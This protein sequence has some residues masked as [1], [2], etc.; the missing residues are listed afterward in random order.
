MNSAQ[1]FRKPHLRNTLIFGAIFALGVGVYVGKS[2]WPPMEVGPILAQENKDVAAPAAPP[3]QSVDLTEPQLKAIKVAPVAQRDFRIVKQAV[4]NVDFNQDMSTQVSSPYQGRILQI[5]AALG[6]RVERGQ[7][8][9]TIES[10][11]LLTAEA[12]L[13]Q[14]AGVLELTSKNLVRLRGAAKIGGSAQKDL[15]Q[16]IADQQ[17]AEGALKAA[18]SALPIFGKSEAEIDQ[19]VASR[20][21]DGAM[22]ILSPVA[23]VVSARNAAP[24]LLVQPGGA[25][26]PFTISDNSQMWLNAYVAESDAPPMAVGQAVL[27]RVAAYP[28]TDFAGKVTW[29]GQTL[30]PA[31]HRMLVRSQIK[32]P[33]RLL[34]AG[35][36]ATFTITTEHPEQSV[37]IPVNGV[38]RMGDGTMTVWIAKSSTHFEQRV[39]TIGIRQDGYAQVLS[40]LAPGEQVIVDGAIFMDNI[41]NAGPSD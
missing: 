6:D 34:R 17:T 30:D 27:A 2:G 12:T 41:L 29:V 21:V 36:L 39:V 11:D 15:D 20:K 33:N 7:K 31:T 35:M 24:G 26:A 23:G 8:L 18:R 19:I 3:P 22:V 28:D 10:P 32:D 16:A 4:G 13:I 40:G 1:P 37:G 14:T 5:F 38:V 25:P 9:F